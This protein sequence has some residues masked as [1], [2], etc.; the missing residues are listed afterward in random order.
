MSC[1]ISP[2]SHETK[3]LRPLEPEPQLRGIARL[4]HVQ[5]QEASEH[6]RARC[7]ADGSRLVPFLEAARESPSAAAIASSRSRDAC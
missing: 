5:D 1:D 6:P 4:G 2:L 3:H 7:V